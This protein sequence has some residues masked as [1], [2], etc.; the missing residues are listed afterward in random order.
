MVVQQLGPGLWRWTGLHPDWT[1]DQG[2]PNGWE[3]EV[4][5]AYYEAPDAVVLVDPLVPPGDEDRFWHA[6]D[7]DIERAGKPVRILV[8][9]HW[10]ARSADA[11]A[12]RYGGEVGGPLP[13]GVEGHPAVCFDETILWIAEHGSLVFGDVVLGA[14]DGRVRLCAESWLE[15]GT[16]AQLK[17]ALRPLLDL[18][19]ERL[20]VSHGEPVLEA[21]RDA[22]ARI[23]TD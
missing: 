7:R 3:Q 5:C 2:G 21:G 20:L 4:G 10:H 14:P 1:P 22:L 12:E 15:G 6:L 11:I 23:L 13:R 17:T 16:H 9:V 18:P 19:V 8:T